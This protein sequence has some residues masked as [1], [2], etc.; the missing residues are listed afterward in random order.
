M[1]NQMW[2]QRGGAKEV[3]SESI[4]PWSKNCQNH[5]PSD[6]KYKTTVTR[7]IKPNEIWAWK[8]KIK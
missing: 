6:M 2:S 1:E 7:I 3:E 5:L 4:Q 8:I